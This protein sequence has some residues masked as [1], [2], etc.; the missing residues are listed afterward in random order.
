MIESA[1]FIIGPASITDAE[2]R[3][4]ARCVNRRIAESQEMK[5]LCA[6]YLLGIGDDPNAPPKECAIGVFSSADAK[7][8][9]DV[10][11]DAAE[12][13]CYSRGDFDGFPIIEMEGEWE[14]QDAIT[15]L[16]ATLDDI[17]KITDGFGLI[18][19][20]SRQ[21]YSAPNILMDIGPIKATR[22]LL[23]RIEAHSANTHD[24]AKED[25]EEQNQKTDANEITDENPDG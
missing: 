15:A 25:L 10:K 4:A 8:E 14:Q 18:N 2:V 24:I 6:S 22:D 23:D 7:Q 3:I 16:S 13:S 9:F 5:H 17:R 21:F 1:L 19:A 11:L 12:K 20:V